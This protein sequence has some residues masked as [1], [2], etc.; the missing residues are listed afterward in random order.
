M[1][2]VVLWEIGR[3]YD[4]ICLRIVVSSEIW[5]EKGITDMG[6]KLPNGLY[7][8]TTSYLCA[9]FVVEQHLGLKFEFME[10]GRARW[11]PY[12]T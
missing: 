6:T 3:A 7:Q 1:W 9:G 8:V 12:K 10:D 2:G 11:V 4:N 5:V